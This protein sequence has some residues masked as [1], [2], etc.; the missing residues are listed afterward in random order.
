MNDAGNLHFWTVLIPVQGQDAGNLHFWTVLIPV[1]GQDDLLPLFEEFSSDS[2]DSARRLAIVESRTLRLV[3]TIGFHTVS[4]RNRTAEIAYDLSPEYWGRGIATTLCSAVT[5][6]SFSTYGFVRV[7]ASVLQTNNRSATV[8][9]RCGF[10]YEGLLRS[11]RMV[12]GTP[13][14][15]AIYSKLATE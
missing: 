1:Q 7:Q 9:Q 12:R 5:A 15:F 8:L 14:D 10:Q 11:F 13:S 2:P 4:S 6:W 3:G